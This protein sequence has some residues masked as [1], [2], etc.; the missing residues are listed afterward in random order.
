M[1]VSMTEHIE[2][3]LGIA[4]KIGGSVRNGFGGLGV[5]RPRCS[6]KPKLGSSYRFLFNVF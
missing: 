4:C 3:A 1:T 5:W 2:A 6:E